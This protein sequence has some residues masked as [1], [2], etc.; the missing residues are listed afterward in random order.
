M[1]TAGRIR[2][3]SSINHAGNFCYTSPAPPDCP[4]GDDVQNGQ[5]STLRLFEDGIEL[6]PGHSMHD[7]IFKDGDGR[8][9]H[10]GQWLM[11][12]SS[13]GSDP[14]S[15]GRT[16]SAMYSLK[17]EPRIAM[18]VAAQNIDY[19]RLGSE[20]KYLWGERVFNALVPDVRVSEFGRTMFHDREF[21]ADYERFDR[22]N[23][24]SFDRKFALLQLLNLVM[25]L[26]GDIAECGVFRGASAY[27]MAKAALG[28]MKRL[29]LFDSFSGVS[30]PNPS[31]DGSY[32]KKGYMACGLD[33]VAVNLQSFADVIFHPGWIPE[34]FPA[35]DDKRF[36]FVH[37]DVDLHQPTHDSLEF[38]FPRMVN[39]GIIVCDDYGFETCPGARKAMDDFAAAHNQKIVHLPTGQGVIFIGR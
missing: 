1:Q 17:D 23:Y 6:G 27:M 21:L 19:D 18:L 29:H 12:S 25:P 14:R 35:V 24:R 26:A 20:L 5:R 4:S 32:W 10:W 7:E 34:K 8:F 38:F 13:D 31:L 15:N 36:C 16:Y 3:L 39:G 22:V 9:S 2:V 11:F 30:E 33:D 28:T 37:L